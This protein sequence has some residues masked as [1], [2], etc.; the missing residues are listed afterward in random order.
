VEI[1]DAFVVA[2]VEVVDGRNAVLVCR[3][4]EGVKNFPAEARILDAPLPA[5]SVV[6]A[7]Q[8]V[9]DVLP[10]IGPHVLPRPS[11]QAEL[12]PIV[13]VGRLAE[14][15]DHTVYGRRA[16]Y[17]LAARI[18]EAAAVEPWLRFGLEQPV[19][20]R[21]SDR[22]QIA[23]WNVK[24]D[25]VVVAARF[26][27]QHAIGGVGGQPVGQHAAGRTGAHD[28]VVKFAFDWCHVRARFQVPQRG[29]YRPRR[30]LLGLGC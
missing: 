11:G 10:E 14:H 9:I 20:A 15:V 18:V 12:A 21:I 17:H 24:P 7:F 29:L 22:E 1:T 28:Y 26:Q 13:I 4:L 16:A 25:P 27:Q 3:L 6:P 5:S 23:D 30:D 2:G 8:E 19:G